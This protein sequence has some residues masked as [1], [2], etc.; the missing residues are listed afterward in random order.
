MRRAR[1]TDIRYVSLSLRLRATEDGG[2]V[3]P[4]K[5]YHRSTF[6]FEESVPVAL[7][8]EVSDGYEDEETP[9][10]CEI[11]LTF[12]TPQEICPGEEGIVVGVFTVG[13]RVEHIIENLP[14]QLKE[15]K[16]VIGEGTV[17]GFPV[18]APMVPTHRE[19]EEVEKSGIFLHNMRWLSEN[20]TEYQGRWVVLNDG[21]LL[22]SA[23]TEMDLKEHAIES[24]DY[25]PTWVLL[26]GRDYESVV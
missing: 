12:E 15:G 25:D 2:R 1:K 11:Q 4:I 20:Y 23:D 9:G 6:S 10:R 8:G 3:S 22:L 17:I 18:A 24:P 14:F 19:E 5:S 21:E 13:Q 7:E 16:K 26:V